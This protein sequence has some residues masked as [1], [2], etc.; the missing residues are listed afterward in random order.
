MKKLLLGIIFLALAFVVPTPTMAARVNVG[1]GIAL[2][3]IVFNTPPEVI[4][5]PD[6]QTVYVVPDIDAELFF[7]NGWWWRPWEGRWYRSHYYN[8]GWVY[9]SN[10]PSFYF[11]I[12]PG[13][14]GYYRERI[15]YGHTWNHERIS[16]ERLL[17]NWKSWHNTR[18]WEK[19]RRWNVHN[20]Q[21][22][23][24]RQI[25]EL[26][27]QRQGQYH[28]RPEV[29]KHL[30]QKQKQPQQVRKLQR[31]QQKQNYQHKSHQRHKKSA[32]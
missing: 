30:Q 7:W 19:Q 13:W 14:R 24:H 22:R 21:P 29:Q 28:Q 12:D 2:P 9:Y 8:R 25:Q 4:V 11:S 1:I 18:Y 15:W 27:H 5:I 16:H 20:Y 10:V 17:H 31:K 32:Y 23:P 6:T 3:P 26:R